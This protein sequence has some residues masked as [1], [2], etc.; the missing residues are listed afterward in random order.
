MGTAQRTQS[1]QPQPL[2][3]VGTPNRN[4][5]QCILMPRLTS[6]SWHRWHRVKRRVSRDRRVSDAR[7]QRNR[8]KDR[9]RVVTWSRQQEFIQRAQIAREQEESVQPHA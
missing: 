9:K 6:G 7:A 2:R 8:S 4:Y 5:P 3:G 1:G